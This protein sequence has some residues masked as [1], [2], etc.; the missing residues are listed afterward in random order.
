MLEILEA[1]L[2]HFSQILHREFGVNYGELPGAGAAGGLGA[3]LM[4]FCGAEMGSGFELIKDLTQPGRTHQQGFAG[5]H[6][7]R[8]NSI[9]KPHTGKRLAG[10][11]NLLKS[12]M[13]PQ[14]HWQPL[15]LRI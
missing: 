3:G 12:T 2:G 10:W 13:S 8:E 1:N 4:A 15:W 5:F 7:G 14:L 9:C 6:S 11:H